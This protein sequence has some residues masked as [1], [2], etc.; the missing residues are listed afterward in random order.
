MCLGVVVS[1]EFVM[2]VWCGVSTL[3]GIL[4]STLGGLLLSTLGDF[5]AS[6]KN[7]ASV[8]KPLICVGNNSTLRLFSLFK[9]FVRLVDAS[10]ISSFLI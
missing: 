8:F 2:D 7:F 5:A 1:V 3:V 6:R 4:S 9:V 10:I